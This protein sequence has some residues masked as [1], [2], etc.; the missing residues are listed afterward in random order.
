MS[1]LPATSQRVVAAGAALGV[2]VEP[3]VFPEGTKTSAD[4]A[5]A[6]GCEVSQIVK[7]LVFMVDDRPVIALLRG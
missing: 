3:R 1:E 7:S 4:A 2:A 5:A 6:I